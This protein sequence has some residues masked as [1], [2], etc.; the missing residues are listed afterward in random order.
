MA[1]VVLLQILSTYLLTGLSWYVQLVHYPLFHFVPK[2]EFQ[3]FHLNHV[4][5][6][7]VIVLFLLPIEVVTSALTAYYGFPGFTRMHW[8]IGLIL[9]AAICLCTAVVQMPLHKK[10]SQEKKEEWIER[11]VLTHWIRTALWT[12]RT[13]LLGGLILSLFR[14]SVS[15]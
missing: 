2:A 1:V 7:N 8:V 3:Q 15:Q 10:L 13:A 14:V 11:L 12:A 9:I 6:T 5:R 4:A